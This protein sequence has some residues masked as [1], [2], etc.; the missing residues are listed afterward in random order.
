M[1]HD[2]QFP[3]QGLRSFYFTYAYLGVINLGRN[4]GRRRVPPPPTFRA[5]LSDFN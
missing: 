4:A 5:D 1:L 3:T 2:S